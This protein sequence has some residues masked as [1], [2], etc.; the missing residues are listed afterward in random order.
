MYVIPGDP[1]RLMLGQRAD[2]ASIEAVR[3]QLGLDDPIYVQYGRF[4][5][6]QSRRFRPILFFKPRC[7]K[8]YS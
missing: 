4:I 2:I 3:K 6:K 8:N 7:F 5:V 1:A